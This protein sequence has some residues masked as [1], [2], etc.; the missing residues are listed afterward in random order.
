MKKLSLADM[1]SVAQ[2][3]GALAVVLS[4]LYVAKGL[5]DNTAAVKAASV[6]AITAGS[7]ESLLSAVTDAEFARIRIEGDKDPSKLSELDAYRYFL[8]TRQLWLNFQNVWTQWKLGVIDD[9]LW[10]GYE[11]AMCEIMASPGMRSQWPRHAHAYAQEFVELVES[12][13]QFQPFSR[14]AVEPRQ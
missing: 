6:T 8:F 5:N 9:Q 4:L 10:T 11:S 12:C 7:R 2:I 14:T 3:V 13:S 1:A